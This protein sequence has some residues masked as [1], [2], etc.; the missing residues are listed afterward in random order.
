MLRRS[1]RLRAKED[2]SSEAADCNEESIELSFSHETESSFN[3]VN[4]IL[5]SD[6]DDDIF[7]SLKTDTRQRKSYVCFALHIRNMF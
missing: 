3:D 4:T 5:C 2:K 7:S 1:G 6:D